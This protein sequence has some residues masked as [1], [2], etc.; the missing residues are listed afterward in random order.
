MDDPANCSAALKASF[1]SFST[2]EGGV[3]ASYI[4]YLASVPAHLVGLSLVL[5]DGQ[6]FHL[7]DSDYR[8]PIESISKV[9]TLALALEQHGPAI[10]QQKIGANPTGMPFNQSLPSNFTMTG[11]RVPWSMLVPW[12][13]SALFRPRM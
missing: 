7:G 5:T 6:I 2:A 3:N 10:V 12:P 4:P 13:P 9:A 8:F 11:P 1:D